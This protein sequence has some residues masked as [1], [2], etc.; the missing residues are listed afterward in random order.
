VKVGTVE[1]DVPDTLGVLTLDLS[2][3]AGEVR[4]TNHYAMVVTVVPE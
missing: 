4:A 1:F 2:L 3:T